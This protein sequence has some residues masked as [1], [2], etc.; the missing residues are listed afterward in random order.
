MAT[1]V[2]IKH[3]LLASALIYI[4]VFCCISGKADQNPPQTGVTGAAGA[5]PAH[6]VAEAL[7]CFDEKHIYSTCEEA[8]RLT[9]TGNLNVPHEYANQYCSGPCLSE[10]NLV[11]NC[12]DNIVSHFEFYNKATIEDVR[13]TIKAGCGYGPQRGNFIVA[14]H[15]K[16]VESSAHKASDPFLFKLMLMVFGLSLATLTRN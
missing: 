4:L 11:L 3:W 15:L 13:E 6:I 14:E 2:T 1:S 12:I 8:Y 7:L 9:E 5:D 10:T 16:A